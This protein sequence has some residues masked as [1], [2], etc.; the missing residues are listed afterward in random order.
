MEEIINILQEF[1][2]GSQDVAVT[3]AIAPAAVMAI[4]VAISALGGIISA[5]KSRKAKE[6]AQRKQRDHEAKIAEIEAGREEPLDPS[7][8]MRDMSALLTNPY[9]NLQVASQA[10]ELQAEETD[11]ALAASLDTLRATGA[12]AGGA[13]AL[14]QAALRSKQGISATIEQ[15][16]AQNTRLRAQGQS[17]MQRMQLSEAGR[18]QGAQ[19]AGRQFKFGVQEQRDMMSLNRY[20]ALSGIQMQQAYAY[21]QAQMMALGSTLGAIGGSIAG[22]ADSDMWKGKGKGKDTRTDAQKA[23]DLIKGRG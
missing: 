5:S 11:I 4:G 20:A 9:A 1:W 2:Y 10:A 16:E 12:S 14:A 22:S 21:Q 13:T 7:E 3:Q 19:M 17:E 18:I 23:M 15:Q 6:E 8:G